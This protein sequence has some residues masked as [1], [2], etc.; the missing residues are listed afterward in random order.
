[1]GS[2][3]PES[4]QRMFLRRVL[5][6]GAAHFGAALDG[7]AVFGWNDRT[8]GAPVRR[9]DGRWWVRATSEHQDY[10]DTQAWTGNAEAAALTDVPKPTLA[11]RIEWLEPPVLITAELM[12]F[13]EDKPCSFTPELRV[14]LDLDPTW[15]DALRTGLDHLAHSHT[16]RRN[17]GSPAY[18]ERLCTFFGAPIPPPD[19]WAT[20]HADLHW[21]NLTAPRLAIL[22]WEYW[23]IAPA[24]YGAATLYCHSLLAPD[25][26]RRIRQTFADLLDTPTGRYCQLSAI[27]FMLHRADNGD[28]PDLVQPLQ[29]LAARLLDCFG[30]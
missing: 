27:M 17:G 20:E 25:T 2:A 5:E 28:Y 9:A 22:D 21:A 6:Q 12:T 18:T 13:I 30:D 26:A 11:D 14:S 24:G 15:F 3:R 4:R 23:G 19:S 10:L 8:V 16:V 1:M 7:P 29:Q